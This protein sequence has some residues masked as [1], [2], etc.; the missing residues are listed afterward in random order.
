MN[1]LVISETIPMYDRGSG[2]LRFYSI[3][4]I[5]SGKHSIVFCCTNSAGQ[6]NTYGKEEVLRYT[7]DLEKSGI[8]FSS[9]D[10]LKAIRGSA[11][12]VI[13][14]EAY[15]DAGPE[16]LKNIRIWQSEAVVIIDT[17]DVHFY[18]LLSKTRLTCNLPE[19]NDF[20]V[21]KEFEL[22]TYN[23]AD[24]IITVTDRDREVLLN[25]APGLNIITIPNM[26]TLPQLSSMPTKME[27]SLIFVGTY[28]HEPNVDSMVYFCKDILP[29]IKKSIKEVKLRIVGNGDWHVFKKLF[30]DDVEIIGYVP[31]MR[32]YLESSCVSIA[33]L[34]F[35]AGMKGKI[36]EAMSYGLPVVSTSVGIEGMNLTHNENVLVGDTPEEFSR[37]TVRL[38]NDSELRGKI[39][40]NGKVF[41]EK[42]YSMDKVAV[43]INELF[44]NLD[45]FLVKKFN[46][47]WILLYRFQ[48][49]IR[50]VFNRHILW[51]FS[52]SMNNRCERLTGFYHK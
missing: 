2:Y 51:R 7:S 10:L 14:F 43:K 48:Y 36:S 1:I 49:K 5:L 22:N 20:K 21:V 17:V 32:P 34:R 44:D 35:G 30:P 24:I 13:F 28:G 18:R 16:I 45:I 3:L 4:K 25:E 15:Y 12:D 33:P 47:V 6:I 27:N 50:S 41:I 8:Q 23:N 37:A 19:S 9:D 26:H 46:P 38:L 29:L 39:G 40:A 31:D 52:R 42:N 11:Y